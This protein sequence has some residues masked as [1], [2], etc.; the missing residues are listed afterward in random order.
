M[1]W[2]PAQDAAWGADAPDGLPPGLPGS[3]GFTEGGSVWLA[4]FFSDLRIH[5]PKMRT[6]SPVRSQVLR[7]IMTWASYIRGHNPHQHFVFALEALSVQLVLRL[8]WE[9]EG[10]RA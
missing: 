8:W 5:T 9:A 2:T 7:T 1:D 3:R 4:H 10:R 6:A